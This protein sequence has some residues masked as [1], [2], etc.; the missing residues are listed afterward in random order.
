MFLWWDTLFLLVLYYRL[1]VTRLNIFFL[2]PQR[3][4]RVFYDHMPQTTSSI[5]NLIKNFE[6]RYVQ[7]ECTQVHF[8]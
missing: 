8:S 4:G 3:Y 6:Q 5:L 2:N 1:K 7:E